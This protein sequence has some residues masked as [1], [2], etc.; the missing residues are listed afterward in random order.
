MVNA[1]KRDY[2]SEYYNK[3]VNLIIGQTINYNY[4]KVGQDEQ[5]NSNNKSLFIKIDETFLEFSVTV[6]ENFNNFNLKYYNSK[7]IIY[8]LFLKTIQK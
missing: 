6:N 3:H 8:L 7:F 5:K 1:P 2:F 4:F